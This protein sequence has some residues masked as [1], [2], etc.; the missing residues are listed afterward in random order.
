MKTRFTLGANSDGI[1]PATENVSFT[2]GNYSATIPPQSFKK[3][4]KGRFKF[5]GTI[6][7]VALEIVIRP[8]GKR[9][10]E[11]KLEGKPATAIG[12]ADPVLV[13]LTIGNDNGSATVKRK[14]DH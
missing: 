14:R 13:S 4:K 1:N 12:S 7:S 5:E 6:N 11:F 3:D 9:K 10:Y 2:I 8:S